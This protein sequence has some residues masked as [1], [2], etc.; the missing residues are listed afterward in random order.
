MCDRSN[1]R[2]FFICKSFPGGNFASRIRSRACALGQTLGI[3][4]LQE[5]SGRYFCSAHPFARMCARSNSR[6]LFIC[7]S[8]PGCILLRASR[9]RFL[10]CGAGQKS[11]CESFCSS[12][13]RVFCGV[14]L[15]KNQFAKVSRPVNR[16]NQAVKNYVQNEKS[17]NSMACVC[18][19]LPAADCTNFDTVVSS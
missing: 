17:R 19:K 9:A 1:S 5:L 16:R 2:H 11:I 7:K 10:R 13:V 8:F 14:A 3:F 18:L 6:H 4:Y 15:R 12:R